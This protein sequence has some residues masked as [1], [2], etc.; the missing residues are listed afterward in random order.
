MQ[1]TKAIYDVI[2]KRWN[3][4]WELHILNVGVTQAHNLRDARE[5]AR[6]FIAMNLA[7]APELVFVDIKPE[8]GA[9]LGT[10]AAA[11]KRQAKEAELARKRAT[12]RL[13]AAAKL[14]K[15]HGLPGVD[16]AVLL[17]VTPQRVSQ[18]VNMP[19]EDMEDVA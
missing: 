13:A 5:M 6:D 11:A 8:L 18:L 12:L 9:G 1:E 16:I 10:V 17:G 7:I 19:D 14:L 4:G 2:A 15:E 3:K